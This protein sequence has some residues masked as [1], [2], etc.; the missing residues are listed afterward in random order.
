MFQLIFIK[1][2][3]DEENP[4]YIIDLLIQEKVYNDKI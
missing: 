3:C 4:Q 1:V 2:S